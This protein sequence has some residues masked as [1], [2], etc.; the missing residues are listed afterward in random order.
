MTRLLLAALTLA[1]IY[2]YTAPQREFAA[3]LWRDARYH[4]ETALTVTP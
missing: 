1:A 4:V 3:D 2:H